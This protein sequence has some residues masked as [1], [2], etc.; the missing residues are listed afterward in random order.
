VPTADCGQRVSRQP[1]DDGVAR[2]AGELTTQQNNSPAPLACA[3]PLSPC[4]RAPQH[5]Q[6]REG[7]PTSCLLSV[8]N[9][10]L[11]R[12]RS[13]LERSSRLSIPT[14]TAASQ[15]AGRLRL[16]P[17]RGRLNRSLRICST[18]V[19]VAAAATLGACGGSAPQKTTTTTTTSTVRAPAHADV[20]SAL[21]GKSRWAGVVVEG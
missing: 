9:T 6:S 1:R 3:M 2:S 15:S 14:S 12:R 7:S 5:C 13:P 4:A 21:T 16:S 10:E 18:V 11:V 19:A 20:L 17:E 8:L